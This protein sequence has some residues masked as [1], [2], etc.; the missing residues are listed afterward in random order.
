M[1]SVL[2][3]CFLEPGNWMEINVNGLKFQF[4][5]NF[6]VWRS[7]DEV[8]DITGETIFADKV[9][10]LFFFEHHILVIGEKLMQKYSWRNAE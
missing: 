2:K 8:I 10:L 6:C 9:T 4:I 5:V 7:G 1:W 3:A